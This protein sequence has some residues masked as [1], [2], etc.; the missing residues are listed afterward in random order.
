MFASILLLLAMADD[1]DRLE[2]PPLSGIPKSVEAQKRDSLSIADLGTLPNILSG[3]RSPLV[4]VRTNESNPAR[5]LVSPA[6]RNRPAG[7]GDPV[8]ILIIER[9]DTFEG[10]AAAQRIAKGHDVVLF[11]GFRFDL[12]S[13]QVV[14]DEQGG[15]IQFIGTGEGAP[16]LV[17]LAPAMMF[18]IKK[19]PLTGEDKTSRPSSG[20]KVLP[21]D[22]AGR[23]R[24]FANG[25]SSG[26]LELSVDEAGVVAGKLRSDQTGGSYKVT[27]QVASDSTNKVRFAIEFPRT[28]Q[29]FD[30]YLFVEGKGAIAGSFLLLDKPYGFFAIRDGGPLAPDAEAITE[31]EPGRAG[32]LKIRLTKS[33]IY[34]QGK[35]MDEPAIVEAIAK[36]RDKEPA[37]W[38]SIEATADTPAGTLIDLVKKIKEAGVTDI[39]LRGINPN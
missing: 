12:D 35:A 4:I 18:T 24:L 14:P 15:D 8:P 32:K 23:F 22:F 2:G 9:F 21:G 33:E 10:G 1:F 25:Q 28:R 27:G 38:V 37:T 5:L 29:E 31:L 30:G 11:D 36:A 13:G 20:R 39:R 26:R 6:L 7:K 34:F 19:S 16:K 17:A 3:T